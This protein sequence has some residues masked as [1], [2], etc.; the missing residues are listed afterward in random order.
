LLGV[1]LIALL[2]L[3]LFRILFL[4]FG[5][6][7]GGGRVGRLLVVGE[8]HRAGCYQQREHHRKGYEPGVLHLGYSPW[9][10]SSGKS[11]IAT[12]GGTGCDDTGGASGGGKAG[13]LHSF[14]IPLILIGSPL[15]C[16]SMGPQP[17]AAPVGIGAGI[18][19]R[20]VCS[21]PPYGK[22]PLDIYRAK[23]DENLHQER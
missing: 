15:E 23:A 17:P 5:V 8:S 16:N 20:A 1:L 3:V 13:C 14:A 10:A 21:S 12:R 2:L 11:E 22:P 19:G 18:S 4:L 7:L 9:R 6:A